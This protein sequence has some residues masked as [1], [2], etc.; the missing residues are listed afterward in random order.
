MDNVCGWKIDAQTSYTFNKQIIV[1]IDSA[2]YVN[3]HLAYG[4]SLETATN[5]QSCS[6]GQSYTIGAD[7]SVY[8]VAVG[9]SSAAFM[10]FEY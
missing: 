1:K 10:S 6:E 9:T 2:S 3:C 4:D 8:V 7:Q 5:Y